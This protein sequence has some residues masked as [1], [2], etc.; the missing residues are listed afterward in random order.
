MLGHVSVRA[1]GS[2]PSCDIWL[3]T[4]DMVQPPVLRQANHVRG[5][6][7]KKKKGL[8]TRKGRAT[9]ETRASDKTSSSWQT[10]SI[11]NQ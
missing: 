11:C 5:W 4:E 9:S 8:K 1:D 2:L 10:T 7:K 6:K 3:L